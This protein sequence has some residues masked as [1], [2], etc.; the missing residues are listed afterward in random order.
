MLLVP[1]QRSATKRVQ[2]PHKPFGVGQW[3]PGRDGVGESFIFWIGESAPKDQLCF[4][5]SAGP[6]STRAGTQISYTTNAHITPGRW[7]HV[8]VVW[9][10]DETPIFCQ[11]G[12]ALDSTEEGGPYKAGC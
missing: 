12:A 2:T 11:D 6:W 5:A 7:C 10:A 9:R 1:S 8:A 4:W 3:G